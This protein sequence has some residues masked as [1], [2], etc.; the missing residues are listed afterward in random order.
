MQHLFAYGTLMC[1]QIMAEASGLAPAHLAGR[2]TGYS[3][4][5]VRGEWY[6]GLVP[7][8]GGLVEGVVYPGIPAPAWKRLDRFEGQMYARET[9]VIELADGSKTDACTYV[10][11]P[12]F[13]RRLSAKD[14]DY[15]SF[16]EAGV[17]RFRCRYSGYG[18]LKADHRVRD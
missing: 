13:K 5:T 6:P 1:P 16:L 7:E 18:H 11:R 12:Q 8:E 17:T 9:V 3:R 14:W 10:F 15:L 2:L 4:R